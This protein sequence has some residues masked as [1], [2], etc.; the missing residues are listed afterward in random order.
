MTDTGI[1]RRQAAK[2]LGVSEAAVRKALKSGRI[3]A[4]ADGSIDLAAA[5]AAW[6]GNTEPAR[7]GMR[8]EVRTNGS[9]VRTLDD[10]R[11]AVSLV[12]RVLQEEGAPA[13]GPF[14]FA[15]ARTAEVV[16]KA[17]QRALD[18]DTRKAKLLDAGAV[19]REWREVLSLVRSKMLAIPSRLQ[20]RLAHLTPYDISEID[21][22][23]RAALTET[24]EG[25]T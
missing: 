20:Q 23:V 22:E 17:R 1:S 3:A 7:N 18:L 12:R 10:A 21:R 2:A 6:A 13:G 9:Q 19:E 11:E 4:R 24:G 8:T 5:R 25:K 14:D 16:L 15:A